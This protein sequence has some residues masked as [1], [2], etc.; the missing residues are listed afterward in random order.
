MEQQVELFISNEFFHHHADGIL[1]KYRDIRTLFTNALQQP[2][3]LNFIDRKK[4]DGITSTSLN[5]EV[6]R[7]LAS[8]NDILFEVNQ[9]DGVYYYGNQSSG[10]DFALIDLHQN[11]VNFRNLCYGRRPFPDG[12]E[13]WRSFV[14]RQP[15]YNAIIEELQ[16]PTP[17]VAQLS[18]DI[19]REKAA[20]IILGEIQFGNWALV[21][22]DLFK[23]LQAN[24]L[25]T[26]DVL[27]YIVADGSLFKSLS[28]NVVNFEDT[29]KVIQEF[30]K[31]I[32]VPVWVVGVDVRWLHKIFLTHLDA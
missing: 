7:L 8:I 10:F 18:T 24:V 22:R 25:T 11:I 3:V 13:Q 29:R 26:V 14:A 27:I 28:D 4:G 32:T 20:P 30:A 6:R 23:V 15:K 19:D 17:S 16:L 1:E 5:I 31:V 9:K 2:A 21:Y 12:Q